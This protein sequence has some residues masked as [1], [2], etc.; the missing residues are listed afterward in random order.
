MQFKSVIE[1]QP[2]VRII[3]R[4]PLHTWLTQASSGLQVLLY[5]AILFL[6]GYNYC[7]CGKKDQNDIPDINLGTD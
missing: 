7:A 3:Q 6:L 5:V 1:M 4:T 2:T